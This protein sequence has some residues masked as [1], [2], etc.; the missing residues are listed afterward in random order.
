M[1]FMEKKTNKKK[2]N[3]KQSDI[4]EVFKILN[5]STEGK[6]VLLADLKEKI[7]YLNSKIPESE[8]HLLTNNK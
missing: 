2:L 5:P 8:I 3:I 6:K 7:P 4:E 1:A